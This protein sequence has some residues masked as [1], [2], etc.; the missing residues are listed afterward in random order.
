METLLQTEWL[1]DLGYWGLFLG[2]FIAGTILTLSSDV[3]LV[4]ILLAGGDPWICL[5][6][7]TV[8]N[9]TGAMVSYT[10]AWFARWEWIERW[11]KV[12]ETTL[13]KQKAIVKKYGVWC[14]FFSW[15]PVVGQ[16]FMLALGF[17]KV[18]PAVTALLTYAGTFCRFLVWVLLYIHYGDDFLV[19][20]SKFL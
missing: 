2:T 10:L 15:L 20:I 8:G 6:A 4:A 1:L 12:K 11:F 9:G 5:V 7:A 17:Y 18:R 14:A 16:L 13:E 3:L 19:W